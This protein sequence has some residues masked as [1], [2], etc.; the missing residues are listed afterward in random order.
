MFL[1][2]SNKARTELKDDMPKNTVVTNIEV[3]REFMSPSVAGVRCVTKIRPIISP[4]TT[5]TRT[6]SKL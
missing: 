2:T 5:D 3:I 4:T 6:L 1:S